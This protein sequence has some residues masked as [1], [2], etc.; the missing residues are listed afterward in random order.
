MMMDNMFIR[1]V[2]TGGDQRKNNYGDDDDDFYIILPSNS[3]ANTYPDNYA[4]SYNVAWEE[5]IVRVCARVIVCVCVCVYVCACVR[6]FSIA[7]CRLVFVLLYMYKQP[8]ITII[9][10]TSFN[11]AIYVCNQC[12]LQY[13]TLDAAAEH[14]ACARTAE[15]ADSST[16]S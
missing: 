1:G 14:V 10:S 8:I 11:S 4:S 13:P 9:S 3:N 15:Y 2:G 6:A 7:T 12:D 5:P 16:C